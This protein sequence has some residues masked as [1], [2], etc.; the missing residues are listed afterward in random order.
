MAALASAIA[1][2][3]PARVAFALPSRS[4]S[5]WVSCSFS[6]AGALLL[7]AA[8]IPASSSS[9]YTRVL[10]LRC[11]SARLISF[12]SSY[13]FHFC[14]PALYARAVCPL[15]TSVSSVLSLPFRSACMHSLVCSLRSSSPQPYAR[16]ARRVHFT[17]CLHARV[18]TCACRAC[19]PALVVAPIRFTLVPAT[20]AL[21]EALGSHDTCVYQMCI[22]AQTVGFRR[23]LRPRDPHSLWRWPW[24]RAPTP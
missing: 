13:L 6:L 9:L 3:Y 20:F 2:A 5:G 7:H 24:L 8:C 10:V 12:S 21:F 22:R 19:A 4:K 16:P 11:G 15:R 18:D 1:L 23:R 14:A 17:H